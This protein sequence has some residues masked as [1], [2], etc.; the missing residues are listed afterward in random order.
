MIKSSGKVRDFTIAKFP[1]MN[2]YDL[3]Q[4]ALLLKD[5]SFSYLQETEPDVFKLGCRHIKV[6]IENYFECLAQT[7]VELATAK[8]IEITAPMEPT[9]K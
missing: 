3:I 1:L 6:F 8:G 5:K 9:K 2:L 4:I 7:D